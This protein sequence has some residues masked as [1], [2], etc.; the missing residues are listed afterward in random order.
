MIDQLIFL[1]LLSAFSFLPGI[2]V[3]SLP[4]VRER[5]L[6]TRALIM[7]GVGIL[8][9][10]PAVFLALIVGFQVFGIDMMD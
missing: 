8:L 2:A 4:R 5:P 3:A 7:L 1:T 10:P 6:W 9:L